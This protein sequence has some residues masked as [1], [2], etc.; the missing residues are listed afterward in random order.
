MFTL[1]DWK[2]EL[3]EVTIV[4]VVSAIIMEVGLGC[5][6]RTMEGNDT[7]IGIRTCTIGRGMVL[8]RTSPKTI[9]P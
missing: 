9:H 2:I 3:R 1:I 4:I 5:E 8:G 7:G 6:R